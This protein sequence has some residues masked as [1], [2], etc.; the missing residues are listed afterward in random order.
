M[1]SILLNS[2]LFALL[3]LSCTNDKNVENIDTEIIIN[4]GG[5]P[6]SMDPT[7]NNESITSTYIFH[8][9][10]SLTRKDKD[11]KLAPGMAESWTISDDGKTYTFKIRENAMWSDGTP[12][13]ANDFVYSFK[14]AV[15]PETAAEYAYMMEYIENA[16]EITAGDMPVDSLM[17]K[18]IDDY[19]LE[20]VLENPTPY[21]LEFMSVVGVY[22]PLREDIIEAN[23]DTWTFNPKTYIGNGAYVMSERNIDEKIV[24][25][26][27]EN[28]W[29]KDE[30]IAP[31][32]T[33][34]LMTDTTAALAALKNDDIHFA[35]PP[36]GEIDK[37][38]EEGF[39]VDNHA[40]G[41]IYV[42]L[43]MTN[44]KLSNVKV[45]QA[46]SLA[47]DRNYLIKNIVKGGQYPAGAVVPNQ[48][49]GYK[50]TFREESIDYVSVKDED[51]LKNV[52]TAK[53][54]LTEAGFPNGEAFPIL[55]IKVTA[56]IY[57]LVAEAMQQMWKENLGIDVVII[58]EDFPITLDN[59]RNKQYEMARMGWTGDYND[60]MTILDI[61]LSTSA[62]NFSGFNSVEYDTLI[63]TAKSTADSK[64]RMDALHK[65]EAMVMEA[66]PV[67]PLYYRA[68]SIMVSPKLKGYVL[69]PL[70]RHKFGYSYIE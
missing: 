2:I 50:K 45:R 4:M 13:T 61:F 55:E 14:R 24:L 33:F 48:I 26:K 65:A 34:V 52:E 41:V 23:P 44:P 60:P 7:L 25:K 68:D 43:N 39:I 37:L 58:T 8:L 29:A 19:T 20:L 63:N 31:S 28:Y 21:F 22:V 64:V 9:F 35:L 70:A 6:R 36:V 12:L 56:G 30:V 46:L 1:K 54:L 69:D 15:N 62:I 67:I 51:Y 11:N 42:A 47:L 10:E 3:F 16:R 66:M 32:L 57:T 38:R 59:L 17:V 40:Y 18:A 5:E 49:A 53:T 27:N